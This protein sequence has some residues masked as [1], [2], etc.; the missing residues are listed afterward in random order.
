MVISEL[1]IHSESV[2]FEDSQTLEGIEYVELV[3]RSN[4]SLLLSSTADSNVGWRI[5]GGIDFTF[6]SDGMLDAGQRLLVV[7]FDPDREPLKTQTLRRNWSIPPT[8]PL[9]GPFKGRLGNDEDR[10]RL[11]QLARLPNPIAGVGFESL[12]WVDEDQVD[13]TASA[14][15]M[16]P[17]QQG[18]SSLSR[19]SLNAF[20][21][22]ASNW[23]YNNPTPGRS[24]YSG[25]SNQP[26]RLIHSVSVINGNMTFQIITEV[27]V[28]YT[29]QYADSVDASIWTDLGKMTGAGDDWEITDPSPMGDARFYRV[30]VE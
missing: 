8:T 4:E 28:S 14:P 29:I 19:L 17:P 12:A 13:Y 18:I 2:A 25:A 9:Y 6:E 5:A 23:V 7:N 15:W 3:N 26:M 10:V 24:N 21:N 11:Q 1:L 22:E 16:T 30:L 20:G 27:G